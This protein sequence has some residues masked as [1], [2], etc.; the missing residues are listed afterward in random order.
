MTIALLQSVRIAGSENA[1]G[2]VLTLAPELEADLVARRQA[3][4]Q[5]TPQ[6]PGRTPGGVGSNIATKAMY[7]FADAAAVTHG[8]NRNWHVQTVTETH[9]DEVRLVFFN[10]HTAAI[11]GL[12]A[13]IGVG[14][15][16][17]ADGSADTITPDTWVDATW[18][19]ASS[20]TLPLGA[21][22]RPSVTVS[23]WMPISSVERADGGVLP[24]LHVR[25]FIPSTVTDIPKFSPSGVMT[26]ARNETTA[27]GRPWRVMLQDVADSIA[28]KANFTTLTEA[29]RWFPFA[30]QYRARGMVRTL[31]V[32]GDSIA[33]GVGATNYINSHLMRA[34]DALS[35]PEAPVELG[36]FAW[37]SQTVAQCEARLTDLITAGVIS[38]GH[39]VHVQAFSPNDYSTVQTQALANTGAAACARSVSAIIAAGAEPIVQTGCPANN[40]SRAW[41][42]TDVYRQKLNYSYRNAPGLRVIDLSV[43]QAAVT[44][45]SGQYDYASGLTTDGLHP[46]DAGNAAAV[47]QAVAAIS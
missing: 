35:T 18:S 27:N 5:N 14:D 4:W 9:F 6:R 1:A 23:D 30:I 13:A 21:A 7:I 40:S 44:T 2:A 45:N 8:V 29:V 31:N 28:T 20:V 16:L 38:R 12:K 10:N 43:L 3:R 36:N 26:W 47:Q 39:L 17:G 41:G 42:A 37:S 32:F 15:V 25:F 33:A 22:A 19:A 11:A 34:R 24:V 46:N